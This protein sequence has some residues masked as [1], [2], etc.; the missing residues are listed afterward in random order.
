MPV[1]TDENHIVNNLL[2][3]AFFLKP[4]EYIIRSP[5]FI[6]LPPHSFYVYPCTEKTGFY[7]GLS[8]IY[9]LNK[10]VTFLLL[11]SIT[12]SYFSGD[13]HWHLLP[14]LLKLYKLYKLHIIFWFILYSA[15]SF[16]TVA[17]YSIA[18][19]TISMFQCSM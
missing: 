16:R 17:L 6:L 3:I 7:T 5:P 1:N 12:I 14:F 18:S 8:H 11:R 9:I 2:I 19:L 13:I 15:V 4:L 10:E